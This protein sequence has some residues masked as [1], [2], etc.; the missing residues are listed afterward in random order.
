MP[1]YRRRAGEWPEGYPNYFDER[2]IVREEYILKL[3]MMFSDWFRNEGLTRNQLQAFYR[4]VRRLSDSLEY[5]T[6]ADSTRVLRKLQALEPLANYSKDR[7][8]IPEVFYEFLKRNI[9][10]CRDRK[11]FR[12]GFAEHFQAVV[13]FCAGKLKDQRGGQ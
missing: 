4:H 7:Q 2:G 9:D 5:V 11:T 1:D 6:E 10:K 8:V 12:H 13:G 3:P